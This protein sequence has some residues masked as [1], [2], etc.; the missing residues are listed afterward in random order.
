ADPA[1]PAKLRD[2]TAGILA[3]MVAGC[4]EWQEHGLGEPESVKSA[5]NRYRE[6]M[7]TLAGFLE[8]HCVVHPSASVPASLLYQRYRKWCAEAGENE[9]PQKRFGMRLSERGFVSA[10]ITNGAH[11]GRKGWFGIGLVVNDSDPDP[12]PSGDKRG[13]KT[14]GDGSLEPEMVNDCSPDENPHFA[15]KTEQYDS[16]VNDSEPYIDILGLGEPREGENPGKRFTSFTSFTAPPPEDDFEAKALTA[17][18]HGN[19]PKKALKT[20]RADTTPFEQVVRSVM[21]YCGRGKDD[22]GTWEHAV[23]LALKTLGQ[24]GQGC[25]WNGGNG[26]NGGG[27]K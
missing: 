12:G 7:D 14:G 2:E 9:E 22:F 3:W 18:R 19:A 6:E 24:D 16:T 23:I 21:Y 26:G 5:T 15:G 17:L 20:Y 8:E 27:A 10:R 11:K 4:L 1:L 13:P 25:S